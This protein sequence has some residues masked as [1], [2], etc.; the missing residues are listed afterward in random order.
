M[1]LTSTQSQS[2]ADQPTVPTV[3]PNPVPDF[4]PQLAR[5]EAEAIA[6]RDYYE[7]GGRW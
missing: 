6:T 2:S 1:T 5:L 7:T 3:N 4:D